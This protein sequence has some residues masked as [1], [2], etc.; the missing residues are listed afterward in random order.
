MRWT[1][2][3]YGGAGASSVCSD[4]PN[5]SRAAWA[6]ASESSKP[7]FWYSAA[8]RACSNSATLT[9]SASRAAF[10]LPHTGCSR[11]ALPRTICC[12]GVVASVAWRNA[13]IAAGSAKSA[14]WRTNHWMPLVHGG[15]VSEPVYCQNLVLSDLLPALKSIPKSRPAGARALTMLWTPA[16]CGKPPCRNASKKP[17]GWP[18]LTKPKDSTATSSA[19]GASESTPRR[20]W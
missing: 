1:H 19:P 9:P 8:W 18:P 3:S 5:A 10:V 17:D 11:R 2:R 14:S 12:S 20:R 16:R 4:R 13:S 6:L 15:A 7:E